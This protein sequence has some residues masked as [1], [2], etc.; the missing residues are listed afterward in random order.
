ML[1]VG[2]VREGLPLDGHVA[3]GHGVVFLPFEIVDH[4]AA[5]R[6]GAAH[7]KR[8]ASN[9]L[10]GVDVGVPAVARWWVQEGEGGGHGGSQ[11]TAIWRLGSRIFR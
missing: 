10:L 8:L 11:R 5:S 9:A 7:Y 6:Q 4:A 3:F 1:L 2:E